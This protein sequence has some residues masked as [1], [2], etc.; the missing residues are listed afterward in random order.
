MVLREEPLQTF[1]A[2]YCVIILSLHIDHPPNDCNKYCFF[3]LFLNM[4]LGSVTRVCI[5]DDEQERHLAKSKVVW[6]HT[7]DGGRR[8]ADGNIY[9]LGRLDHQVKRLGKR[10]NLMAIEEVSFSFCSIFFSKILYSCSPA[11]SFLFEECTLC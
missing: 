1:S 2:Q 8:E 10:L 11:F 7:G 4:I 6:R 3:I 9:Y 5:I